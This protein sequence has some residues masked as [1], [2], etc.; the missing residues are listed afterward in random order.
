MN[1]DYSTEW[2]TRYQ[3][4]RQVRARYA[5]LKARADLGLDIS[6]GQRPQELLRLAEFKRKIADLEFLAVSP[7]VHMPLL[8]SDASNLLSEF[9]AERER[10]DTTDEYSDAFAKLFAEANHSL[11]SIISQK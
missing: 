6:T 10:T 11:N 2:N 3:R 9:E 7:T 8:I 1:S 5:L 4:R